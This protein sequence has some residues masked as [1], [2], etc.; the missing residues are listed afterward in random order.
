MPN[1][2]DSDEM[3]ISEQMDNGSEP[4]DTD[5]DPQKDAASASTRQELTF[6]QKKMRLIIGV[7]QMEKNE[8]VRVFNVDIGT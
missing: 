4:D 2:S 5:Y 7:Y 8:N 3:D 6:K 1:D